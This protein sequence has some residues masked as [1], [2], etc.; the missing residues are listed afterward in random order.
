MIRHLIAGEVFEDNQSKNEVIVMAARRELVEQYLAAAARAGLEVV[1]VCP[2]PLAIAASLASVPSCGESADPPKAQAFIDIGGSGTRVYIAQGNKIQFA[3]AVSIGSEQFDTT[4]ATQLRIPLAQARQLRLQL[5]NRADA[6]GAPPSSVQPAHPSPTPSFDIV[7]RSDDE[8]A[9]LSEQLLRAEQACEY[10]LSRLLQEI[11]H[12]RRYYCSTFHTTPLEQ[13]VFIG[14][15]A[16]QRRLC[17]NIAKEL[18]LSAKIGDPIESLRG[19]TAPELTAPRCA[20]AVAVGLSM[21]FVQNA[22]R[23]QKAA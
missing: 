10:P 17:Q 9:D 18:H 7:V 8:P 15:V 20:W 22:Q 2:E 13:V 12:C 21:C 1:S 11:D 5:S 19:K 14:G 4:I 16:G 3:R 6:T 23:V